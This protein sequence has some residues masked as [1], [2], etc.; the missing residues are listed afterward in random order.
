M[1]EDFRTGMY[2]SDNSFHFVFHISIWE[3]TIID[4]VVFSFYFIIL[5]RNDLFAFLKFL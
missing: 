2:G 5:S 3:N 4:A 1:P